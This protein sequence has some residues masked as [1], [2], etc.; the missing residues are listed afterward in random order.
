MRFAKAYSSHVA[1]SHS[2]SP[3]PESGDIVVQMAACGICG[4]DL[5]KVYG[6]YSQPSTKLGHEPAGVVVKTGDMVKDIRPGDRVFVHHH[7]PCYSCY[8][9]RH[10]NE[11]RC[12]QYSKSNISPCGLSEEFLVPAWNIHNG[13]V[14]KLPDGMS[15]T[16]AAMIEPL[17][18]C[19]RAWSKCKYMKGDSVAIF[20]AGSTGMMHAML[21]KH[22]GF[23]GIYCIDTNDF[24][25]EYARKI[26]VTGTIPVGDNTPQQ[27]HNY[28]SGYGV[29]LAVVATSSMAALQDA[30]SSVRYGGTVM[31]FGVPSKGA[32]LNINMD[33][34]YSKEISL[35]NSYAASDK[36]TREALKLLQNGNIEA[37]HLVTHTY[38]MADVSEAFERARNGKDAV[39]VV[40][41]SGP[42]LP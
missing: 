38:D 14:I 42:S 20:G 32:S 33:A 26:G 34:V 27:L 10:G 30:I 8:L 3:I 12:P 17:A 9:C 15:Y 7:V 39:K 23:L 24:R 21:A 1:I 16:D 5:E 31:M 25:L 29:D 11:T 28:T 41:T 13:G 36:D 2:P 4:S 37:G 35:L 18:C 22:Y 40:V 6:S 19:V